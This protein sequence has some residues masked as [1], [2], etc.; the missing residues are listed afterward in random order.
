ML[1]TL[2]LTRPPA[3]D[4][5]FLLHKHPD[6][7][8]AQRLSFGSAHVFYPEAGA[9]RCT[10]A[11]LLEVD[12][13]ALVRGHGRDDGP[14]AQYVNDRPYA[15]SSF[16]SVAIGAVFGT[17]LAGRCR[18]RPELP[19]KPLPFEAHLPAL[20]Y[21]GDSDLP[22][23]LFEPLGYEVESHSSLLDPR[24]P[25]WGTSPYLDV[26][27]R[28]Q[29]R[30]ADL[31]R[32]LTVMIPVLDDAK[33]YWVGDDEVEKLLRRGDGWLS[34]H[35]EQGLIAARYLKRRRPLVAAA[36]DRLREEGAVTDDADEPPDVSVED[37]PSLAAQRV[38]AAVAALRAAGARRVI[39]L[40]CGDGRLLAALLA[41]PEFE[42]VTGMDVSARALA[43]A[44]RR[45]ELDR[46]PEPQR[47]RVHLIHGSLLYRDARLSGFDAA[48]LVEVIEHVD[49]AR[50]P[51]MEQVVF[52]H[53]R[54][55]AVIVTTPNV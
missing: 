53:A 31:L 3:T 46:L 5:G 13:I 33:H 47:A 29:V 37:R 44:A 55:G 14:L 4:L 7:A 21:R 30:L 26:R 43:D 1:L 18:E 25:E 10:A 16:L 8:Q 6:R 38:T 15:A 36:L 2:T 52:G 24:S 39:D 34:T 22:R 17:A 50:L 32:H 20:P 35:P 27:L 45:L 12:P 11:L 19:E 23:R 40:G 41:D 54:P 42:H 51:A 48:A 28:G 9:D 49:P